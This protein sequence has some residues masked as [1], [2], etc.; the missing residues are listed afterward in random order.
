MRALCK[1]VFTVSMDQL[2]VLAL[3]LEIIGIT[4]TVIHIYNNDFSKLASEWIEKSIKRIGLDQFVNMTSGID[5]DFKHLTELERE[6]VFHTR[7]AT[8]AITF[9]SFPVVYISTNYG[10]GVLWNITEFISAYLLSF[11]YVIFAQYLLVII[12]KLSLLLCHLSGRGDIIIGIGLGLATA[13]LLIEA[14]QIYYSSLS[15]ALWA[16]SAVIMFIFSIFLYKNISRKKS[17]NT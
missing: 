17:H 4:L 1:G 14:Y 8:I 10:D 5:Y 15:S 9:L 12:V 13:G 3:I 7:L 16:I 2:Q 6:Q 11:L